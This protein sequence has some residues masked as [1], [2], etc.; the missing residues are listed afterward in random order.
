MSLSKDVPSSFLIA[1]DLLHDPRA[2]YLPWKA[3]LFKIAASQLPTVFVSGCLFLVQT[4]QEYDAFPLHIVSGN[5]IPAPKLTPPTAPVAGDTTLQRE[6]F[7]RDLASYE[8][9]VLVRARLKTAIIASILPADLVALRDPVHGDLLLDIP[10][11]LA[12]VAS[13]HGNVTAED[14][15]VWKAAL[16]EKLSSP[17]DFLKHVALFTERYQRVHL[18]EPI[19]PSAL[20]GIFESTFSHLPAFS[21]SLGRFYETNPDRKKHTVAN[22][23]AHITPS[24]PYIQKLASPSHAAFVALGFPEPPLVA[25]AVVPPASLSK[26]ALK[27]AAKKARQN[28]QL[29]SQHTALLVYL[30]GQGVVVPPHLAAGA[31]ALTHSPQA[32]SSITPPR[33]QSRTSMTPPDAF[34]FYCFV[35]GWTKSHGWPTGGPWQGKPCSVL[36]A[37]PCPY[38]SAQVN[39]RDPSTGGN[40]NVYK[41]RTFPPRLPSR[42]S[43]NLTCFPCLP[44]SSTAHVSRHSS[45]S[46]PFPT[47]DPPRPSLSSQPLSHVP[48][49]AAPPLQWG[50]RADGTS[51][52]SSFL[53]SCLSAPSDASPP[54]PQSILP[55]LTSASSPPSHMMS[56]HIPTR[57]DHHSDGSLSRLSSFPNFS[58]PLPLPP[59]FPSSLDSHSL[60]LTSPLP[61]LSP[62]HNDSSFPLWS[63]VAPPPIP[64]IVGGAFSAFVDGDNAGDDADD[65]ADDNEAP[66]VAALLTP[67]P[68]NPP[69]RHPSPHG[70]RVRR[71]NGTSPSSPP[72]SPPPLCPPA[73][74]VRG[75]AKTKAMVK[76]RSR[77]RKS[78]TGPA[79]HPSGCEQR[80]GS[81]GTEGKTGTD[82]DTTTDM[83]PS[84]PGLCRLLAPGPPSAPMIPM[85]EDAGHPHD[86]SEGGSPRD[87]DAIPLHEPPPTPSTLLV[88]LSS[89][90]IPDSGASHILLRSSSLPDI[91]HLFTPSLVPP[92][93]LSQAIGAPLVASQGGTLS[94]PSRAPILTYII[95][96]CDLAHNL[97]SVSALIGTDGRALFTPT[98]VSFFSP[99]SPLPFLTGT[100]HAT[101]T[102]WVLRIPP[103]STSRFP[104]PTSLVASPCMPAQYGTCTPPHNN[105]TCSQ[106]RHVQRTSIY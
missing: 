33:N 77:H 42:V 37:V 13:I 20:F 5:V 92:I 82:P 56:H 99:P 26:T 103:P 100:K 45:S 106:S 4:Q 97:W 2:N 101:D 65:G 93:T 86:P 43:P 58:T 14:L 49:S 85:G 41:V 9:L 7:A 73:L 53:P 8:A 75:R 63:P 67:A 16:L 61:V 38:T 52:S 68:S 80:W 98:S 17:A 25:P 72:S 66:L 87:A 48:P 88:A 79:K 29:A 36:H 57:W 62:L 105:F 59:P 30:A 54:S 95:P 12:H 74:P 1:P 81:G 89:P 22:L 27:K 40:A 71:V 23:V 60:P 3:A 6:A 84:R 35:H 64:Q 28:D 104:S 69:P 46:I 44:L 91:A 50:T 47:C 55:P 10:T 15:L 39:A 94:F 11:I 19:A 76:G 78:P 51:P 32:S 31:G 83:S 18:E 102:L 90:H 70:S 24:L 21:P 34:H 96:P